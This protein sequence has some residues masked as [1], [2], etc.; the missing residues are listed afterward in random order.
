MKYGHLGK[1]TLEVSRIAFGCMSLGENKLENK[2]LLLDAYNSGINFFDTADLYSK[3]ENE[4]LLVKLSVGF[5]IRSLSQ[6]KSVM[7]GDPMETDGTGILQNNI[8]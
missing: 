3:G 6:Q 1:S 4:I 8:F 2:R 5:V 7:N